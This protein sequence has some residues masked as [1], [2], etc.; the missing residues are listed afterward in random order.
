MCTSFERQDSNISLGLPSVFQQL[1]QTRLV[2]QEREREAL[3]SRDQKRRLEARVQALSEQLE[4]AVEL[5][6]EAQE[7]IDFV[8]SENSQVHAAGN[9]A[10]GH[11]DME[12]LRGARK[13]L[14]LTEA[15]M[16]GLEAMAK[17]SSAKCEMF[18]RERAEWTR[19]R[20]KLE[21]RLA[22]AETEREKLAAAAENRPSAGE[23]DDTKRPFVVV[24]CQDI[25]AFCKVQH[26]SSTPGAASTAPT[27][28]QSFAGSHAV[29]LDD[30]FCNMPGST[31]ST[32][33]AIPDYCEIGGASSFNIGMKSSP[34]SVGAASPASSDWADRG[35]ES[36]LPMWSNA[37][38]SPST[39]G[40]FSNSKWKRGSLSDIV[41]QSKVLAQDAAAQ[42]NDSAPR[43]TLLTDLVKQAHCHQH[44]SNKLQAGLDKIRESRARAGETVPLETVN[45]VTTVRHSHP[46]EQ[47]SGSRPGVY[48]VSSHVGARQQVSSVAP[49]EV[50]C[51]ESRDGKVIVHF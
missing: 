31:L 4:Q 18:Q 37:S 7:V 45:P 20:A 21:R 40:P 19:E 38:K 35:R 29:D 27:P 6:K 34:A 11:E 2:L 10:L 49:R 36:H 25:D 50:G 5:A 51:V 13:A 33:L 48:T 26:L 43:G 46:N 23:G 32:S 41:G 15:R 14:R 22:E 12:A 30:A 8:S 16:H 9:A 3:E 24:G 17:R 44:M 1:Q 39:T 28:P 42:N 47:V